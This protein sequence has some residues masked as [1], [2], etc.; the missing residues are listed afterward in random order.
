MHVWLICYHKKT[1]RLLICTHIVS[2][3]IYSGEAVEGGKLET[4]WRICIAIYKGRGME[5]GLGGRGF[6][7]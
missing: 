1:Q 2:P 4:H 6:L 7:Q 5:D 3:R